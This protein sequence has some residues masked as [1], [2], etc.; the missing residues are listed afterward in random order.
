M[1][2]CVLQHQKGLDNVILFPVF[3]N[4]FNYN[5]LQQKIRS[6]KR[7]ERGLM[8]MGALLND[9]AVAM[10]AKVAVNP[11]TMNLYNGILYS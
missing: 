9:H 1:T 4:D 6:Q 8:A 10:I 3:A 2:C 11:K 7:K 5:P